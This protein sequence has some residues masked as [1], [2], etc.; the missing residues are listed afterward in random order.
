MADNLI[1]LSKNNAFMFLYVFLGLD[2]NDKSIARQVISESC[3]RLF[4][5]VEDFYTN[6]IKQRK[7]WKFIVQKLSQDDVLYEF[8]CYSVMIALYRND[9][10]IIADILQANPN[11][12]A[13]LNRFYKGYDVFNDIDNFELSHAKIRSANTELERVKLSKYLMNKLSDNGN[14]MVA[15]GRFRRCIPFIIA[16]TYDYNKPFWQQPVEVKREFTISTPEPVDIGFG[17]ELRASYNISKYELVSEDDCL[18]ISV[19]LNCYAM[20]MC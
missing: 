1:Q 13:D 2:E 18:D 7:L 4:M 20:E 17:N 6:N 15:E 5:F 16:S 11:I 10:H 3:I 14:S 9:N 19:D 12:V 8:V